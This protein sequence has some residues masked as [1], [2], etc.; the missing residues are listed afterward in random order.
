M[1]DAHLRSACKLMNDGGLTRTRQGLLCH[2]RRGN[3]RSRLSALQLNDSS[4][5]RAADD[6]W[7]FSALTGPSGKLSIACLNDAARLSH[8]SILTR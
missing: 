6:F 4:R 3:S 7:N 2:Q 5:L 1:A 8:L